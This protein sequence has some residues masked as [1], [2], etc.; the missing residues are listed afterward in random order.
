M[1]LA[2]HRIKKLDLIKQQIYLTILAPNTL[3]FRKKVSNY[4]KERVWAEQQKI[5]ELDNGDIA[6]TIT[7]CS[8]PELMAWVRSFGE[9]VLV[10]SLVNL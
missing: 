2:I 4:I 5:E 10:S 7:T 8:E 6:L 3:Q 1:C 9:K